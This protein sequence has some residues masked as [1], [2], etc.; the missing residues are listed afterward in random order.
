[1]HTQAHQWLSGVK[2]D[3]QAHAV[4]LHSGWQLSAFPGPTATHGGRDISVDVAWSA[5][6]LAVK[7]G[8]MPSIVREHEDCV[9]QTVGQE[10][11]IKLL[12]FSFYVLL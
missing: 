2:R 3:V 10:R 4:V 6:H 11:G 9:F 8:N 7:E 12:A 1:M 5:F